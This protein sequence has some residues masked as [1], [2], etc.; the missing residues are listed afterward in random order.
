MY[1]L[2]TGSALKI[3][4]ASNVI[5]LIVRKTEIFEKELLPTKE[6]VIQTMINE[7]D[8]RTVSAARKVAKELVSLWTQNNVYPCSDAV[9]ARTINDLMVLFSV[10][11]RYLVSKLLN[12]WFTYKKTQTV[13]W[14]T[15][16]FCYLLYK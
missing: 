1:V 8:F 3:L 7:N 2:Y 5:G 16:S 6:A 11:L 15:F 9:V 4:L 12:A 14:I 10:V 13:T